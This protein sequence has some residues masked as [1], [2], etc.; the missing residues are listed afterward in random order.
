MWGQAG[1][2][3]PLSSLQRIIPTRVGTSSVIVYT[4]SPNRDHPHACGDK[5]L[6]PK[7][8]KGGTGSSPRVWGQVAHVLNASWN[9]RI[10]PTRVGTSILTASFQGHREDHPHACGDKMQTGL[11]RRHSVGSSPRVWGQAYASAREMLGIR[12]IPTRVGTS[13]AKHV[14]RSVC[15]DHPHACGDKPDSSKTPRPRSGSSP[16]VWGQ[17]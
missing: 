6:L 14:C 4:A 2:T 9:K 7:Q 12:I 11:T 3:F 16:R 17:V 8:I 13:L 10:I 5:K 1:I 15:R